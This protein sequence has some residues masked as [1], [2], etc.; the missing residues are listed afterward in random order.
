MIMSVIKVFPNWRVFLTGSLIAASLTATVAT[1]P[2]NAVDNGDIA[3]AKKDAKNALDAL[4]GQIEGA[5][6][7]EDSLARENE[8]LLKEA[9]ALSKQSIA[10]ATRI[11]SREGAITRAEHRLGELDK[12]TEALRATL[13]GKHLV[14]SA[15]LVGLQRLER[16]FPPPLAVKPDDALEAVRGAMLLQTLVPKM[17]DE[18][19]VVLRNLARLETVHDRK[20][21]ENE[22]IT[23]NLAGLGTEREE[24]DALLQRKRMLIKTTQNEIETSH[25]RISKLSHQAASVRQLLASLE[26]QQ[27]KRER[28]ND[29]TPATVFTEIRGK[30]N[31]PAQGKL[32]SHYGSHNSLGAV[33][34]GDMIATR[35]DA[36]VTAPA[37][38]RVEFAGTFRSYGK[39][40]ILDVGQGYHI[41]M[42]GLGTISVGNGEFLLAGEPVGTMGDKPAMATAIW[43][44]TKQSQPILYIEFRKGT[45]I[46]D[47]TPWWS[48]SGREARR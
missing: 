20:I 2:A 16:Q 12:E 26:R 41:L 13:S 28:R 9:G 45:N 1:G 30:L 33:V 3:R 42:A 8:T 17:E 46:I 18:A 34:K 5:R 22:T 24:I 44:R 36:Q 31:F 25:G 47:P 39:L 35:A 14:L 23:A 37:D 7:R 15:L 21:R 11:Q 10:L 32:V 27:K 40:L 6:R 43:D 38:G 29:A 48:G 19:G 4:D